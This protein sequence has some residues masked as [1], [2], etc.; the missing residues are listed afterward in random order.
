MI[1]MK[2]EIETYF[3]RNFP[4]GRI[5]SLSIHAPENRLPMS[6]RFLPARN[7]GQVR[8]RIGSG[9]GEAELGGELGTDEV[10]SL[11]NQDLRNC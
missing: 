10:T 9:I 5:T 2:K 7:W 8:S 1:R 6:G 11:E 4:V 3:D